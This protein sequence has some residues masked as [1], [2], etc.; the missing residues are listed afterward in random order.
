MRRDE[1][2]AAFFDWDVGGYE[3]PIRGVAIPLYAEKDRSDALRRIQEI[4]Q[5]G[6]LDWGI[7]LSIIPRGGHHIIYADVT[8]ASSILRAYQAVITYLIERQHESSR[9]EK[10]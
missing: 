7:R 3:E 2:G 1:D 4:D 10:D 8:E 9:I 5:N 6:L